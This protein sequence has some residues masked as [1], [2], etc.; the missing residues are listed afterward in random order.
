M[1]LKLFI[2]G[3]NAAFEPD[4]GPELARI[5]STLAATLCQDGGP[6]RGSRT[7][8]LSDLNGNL[9]GQ[10]VWCAAPSAN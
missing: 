9:V 3:G 10:A 8:R 6:Q 5:L 7:Y 4:P 1:H 2:D